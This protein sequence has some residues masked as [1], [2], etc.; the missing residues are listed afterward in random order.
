MTFLVWSTA[1]KAFSL[2]GMLQATMVR[3]VPIALGGS[4]GV[5]SERVA[6]VNITIEGMLLV[7][8]FTGALIGSL[9]ERRD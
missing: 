2:T 8:A 3:A 9:L 4:A 5:L 7:G 6:V 1:G